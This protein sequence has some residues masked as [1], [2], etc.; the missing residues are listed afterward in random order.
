MTQVN[1]SEFGVNVAIAQLRGLVGLGQSC[2]CVSH[3]QRDFHTRKRCETGAF[4]NLDVFSRIGVVS[5]Q[6]ERGRTGTKY[7]EP[8]VN[9]ERGV[10][11]SASFVNKAGVT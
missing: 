3:P 8:G 11:F 6:T 10:A 7:V 4:V 2:S 5:L 9:G 1:P